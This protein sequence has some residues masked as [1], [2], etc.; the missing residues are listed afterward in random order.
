MENKTQVKNQKL[1]NKIQHT[2]EEK[3]KF[4][5]KNNKNF[6]KKKKSF[7]QHKPTK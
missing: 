2:S 5:K 7:S 6:P 3:P 1:K 4:T